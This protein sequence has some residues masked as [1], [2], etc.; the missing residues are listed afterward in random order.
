MAA[1]GIR[2]Q[3]DRGAPRGRIMPKFAR[4][5]AIDHGAQAAAA[6]AARIAG[7]WLVALLAIACALQ[8]PAPRATR[9]RGD[10]SGLER[11]GDPLFRHGDVFRRPGAPIPGG[12]AIWLAP[13]R[14]SEPLDTEG[15]DYREADL[16]RFERAATRRFRAALAGGS[17]AFAEQPTPDALALEV[18]VTQLRANAWPDDRDPVTGARLPPG[19]R[20]FGVGSVAMQ[21][22]LRDG[23]S[24]E[25]L[26][27]AVDRY[28]GEELP[29]NPRARLDFGD[30]E[31][32]M[33]R[34]GAWL[35]RLLEAEVAP[36]SES[37]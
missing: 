16:R 2:W 25:L 35:R 15:H 10:L 19:T 5:M 9:Y 34:W 17:L 12:R 11:S 36:D 37:S 8:R 30:A 32:A 1:A 6:R 3:A 31:Y 18:V 23:S 7:I 29:H 20:V 27:A 21:L 33:K 22:E 14:V 24:R 13:V 26:L 4:G 28:R